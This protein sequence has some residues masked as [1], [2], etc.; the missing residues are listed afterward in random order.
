[1]KCQ[2]EDCAQCLT[3]M[4][5]K[6]QS[7]RAK[8]FL[9]KLDKSKPFDPYVVVP[10]TSVPRFIRYSRNEGDEIPQVQEYL[11]LQSGE[12]HLSFR[13]LSP[14]LTD[15][16]HQWEYQVRPF[17]SIIFQ[18]TTVKP[19]LIN[20]L[21]TSAN[22]N[23][24]E[25]HH[26]ISRVYYHQG[27]NWDQEDSFH[28]ILKPVSILSTLAISRHRNQITSIVTKENVNACFPET[29]EWPYYRVTDINSRPSVGWWLD[30][31]DNDA[32]KNLFGKSI[33]AYLAQADQRNG[34][35]QNFNSLLDY[36]YRVIKPLIPL[37]LDVN[38]H[39]SELYIW[40]P[41]ERT[42]LTNILGELIG[43]GLMNFHSTTHLSVPLVL[44]MVAWAYGWS[45]NWHWGKVH[46][47]VRLL[48]MLG[49]D[50]QQYK[51]QLRFE[52]HVL[53]LSRKRRHVT[54]NIHPVITHLK[55]V[56]WPDWEV[57]WST[58][59][60]ELC[61]V[62]NL[63]RR[64]LRLQDIAR[65]SI[66]RA[67]GGQHF[68]ARVRKLSLPPKMKAFVRADITRQLLRMVNLAAL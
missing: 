34:E 15:P 51:S 19:D 3:V 67:V 5:L 40:W 43:N 8:Q 46:L 14:A 2:K 42:S 29:I 21:L 37:G 18:C 52:K 24:L 62:R 31:Y 57:M 10:F 66:R 32:E 54:C 63:R 41:N 7:R 49:A 65:I 55:E 60:N 47:L 23:P 56:V 35:V 61:Y 4:V 17:Y 26:E 48:H 36:R 59:E 28:T 22:F 53:S 38:V 50:F 9:A 45:W 68:K 64:P 33:F 20:M 44:L 6:N 39:G 58:M 12:P 25:I 16:N 27:W 30:K 1:M 11:L 13:E